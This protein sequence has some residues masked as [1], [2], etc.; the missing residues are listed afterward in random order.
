MAAEYEDA[1]LKAVEDSM[2]VK[3]TV[4]RVSSLSDLREKRRQSENAAIWGSI[5]RSAANSHAKHPVVYAEQP[6]A[7]WELDREPFSLARTRSAEELRYRRGYSREVF[8]RC[9][10]PA[11]RGD[12]Q[13]LNA[14]DAFTRH[15]D[16]LRYLHK[17][18]SAGPIRTQ[19]GYPPVTDEN[20]LS[21]A[22]KPTHQSEEV[23]VEAS[24]Q[25][26][27]K[28]K[29]IAWTNAHFAIT[30]PGGEV[31]LREDDL[32]LPEPLVMR[33]DM[34]SSF[35]ADGRFRPAQLPPLPLTPEQRAEKRAKAR[36]AKLA[37]QAQTPSPQATSPLF[38][39]SIGRPATFE[40]DLKHLRMTELLMS[41][42][43]GGSPLVS[44]AGTAVPIRSGGFSL[45][46]PETAA[47]ATPSSPLVPRLHLPMTPA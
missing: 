4:G 16:D 38:S 36:A 39:T 6:H 32:P 22:A 40:R 31:K 47:P 41:R 9:P 2:S 43:S 45:I 7:F 27:P 37:K 13:A 5:R 25:A 29:N 3:M 30:L 11:P 12:E 21:G 28:D 42:G 1:R 44:R 10:A 19:R 35:S 14:R 33:A 17:K 8:P 24:L 34:Y 20:L 18:L 46:G 23:L 26:D 15:P